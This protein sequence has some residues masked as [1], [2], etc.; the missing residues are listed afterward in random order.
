[1]NNSL[2]RLID[3]MIA[4]LRREVIP[5]TE[6]E[7]ARGQAF[8]VVYMLESIKRRASWS[9]A[10]LGEQL[11][12][13]DGLGRDLAALGDHF[14][15]APLPEPTGVGA[16]PDAAD[17]ERLRDAGDAGICRLIDW[18]AEHRPGLPADAVAAADAAIDRYIRRQLRFELAT[19]ARPMFEEISSGAESTA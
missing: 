6:G 5:R 8:G 10:F 19:S 1:M 2:P 11:A 18:L 9:N 12:A 4:A 16:L 7:F 13:L 15:G 3:G 14:P 17:L